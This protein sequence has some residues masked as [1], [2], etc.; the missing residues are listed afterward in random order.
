MGQAFQFNGGDAQVDFGNTIGNFGARDFT[1]AFWLKTD[2]KNQHESL[3]SKRA[4]CDAS[5]SFWHVQVGSGVPRLAK[6]GFIVLAVEAGGS[7][8]WYD[9]VSSHPMNDGKWHYIVWVRQS[10][11]SGSS[12]GLIY[13]DGALDNSIIYP[14]TIDLSNQ[15]DLVLGHNVCECCDGCRPYSGAAADLQIFSH[16]LSAEEI[17]AIYNAGKSAK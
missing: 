15:A 8:P 11:S 3:L 9:L 4:S 13:V 10:T 12:T 1:I 6:T 16:A 5:Q 17:L 2:S 14:D 7:Q